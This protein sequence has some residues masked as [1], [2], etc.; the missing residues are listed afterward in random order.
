[1]SGSPRTLRRFAP[2]KLNLRLRVLQREETGYHGVETLL[3]AL[4]LSDRITLTPGAPGIRLDVEGDPGVPADSTNLCWRAAESLYRATGIEPA[5]SIQ[6][7]KRIP[8]AAGLGRGSS[9]A[10]ATLLALNEL[11][12]LPVGLE[13]LTQIAGDLGS[14]VPFGLAGSP[15]A[16]GWERGR[17]LIPLRAP[18]ARPVAIAVPP[19]GV[20]AGDAY[21]W[22]TA[23]RQAAG[24]DSGSTP[25]PAGG[26]VL[27]P[28]DE[29]VD[30]DILESLVCNDLERPVFGRHPEL[31]IIRDALLESGASRAIL[32]G[33]GSCVAGIFDASEVRDRAATELEERAGVRII[34]TVTKELEAG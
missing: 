25:E 17:R 33:S 7:E 31:R 10:S 13:Q 6:L 27:P 29:L 19:F 20:S 3:L 8:S 28:P 1:M 9:D 16:L 5:I 32:C 21:R 24:P 26:L 15:L 14:D 22:L 2:A 12:G 11:L 30:W 18:S 23:D 4:E 34:R